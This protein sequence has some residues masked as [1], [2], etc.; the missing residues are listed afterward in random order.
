MKETRQPQFKRF[1]MKRVYQFML[2]LLY[3]LRAES[4]DQKKDGIG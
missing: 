1:C 3:Y 2:V 4:V